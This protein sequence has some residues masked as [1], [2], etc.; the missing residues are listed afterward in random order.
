MTQT[1]EDRLLVRMETTL[2]RFEREMERGRTTAIKTAVDSERAWARAGNQIAA[3]SNRA[4]T[5]MA[6]LTQIS[7]SGRFVLQNTAA[8]LGD[9]AVQLESGTNPMRVMG[10]QFPQLL[11]GFGALGGSLGVVAPLLGVIAAIGFPVAGMLLQMGGNSEEASEKVKTFADRLAEVES[12]LGRAQSALQRAS[13]GGAEDLERIYGNVT[14]KVRD[15]SKALLDIE[16]RAAQVSVGVLLDDALNRDYRAEVE[17]MFG[18]VGAALVG[19]ASEEAK[20]QAEQIRGLISEIEAQI[21]TIT[22]TGQAEPLQL[23]A[24]IEELNKELAAVEG[25]FEDI[26]SLS[27]E[28]A[29]APD[30]LRTYQ[31]METRLAAA[32]EAGDFS[33]IAN[34]LSD[35]RSLLDTLGDTI[36]QEVRDK[37]TQAED[38]ARQFAKTLGEA[39]DVTND[40]LISAGGINFNRAIDGA[41]AL[42]NRLRISLGLARQIA[43]VAGTSAVGD[44]VFDERSPQFNPKAAAEARRQATLAEI[45]EENERINREAEKAARTGGSKRRGGSSGAGS[46][47]SLFEGAELQ[48]QSLERQIDMIGKTDREITRLTTRYRLLDEAKK[49]NV[50]LDQRHASTGRTVREEIDAQAEAVARLTD[51]LQRATETSEF[52][53][54]IQSDLKEGLLDGV[55]EANSFSDALDLVANRL[56]RAAAEALL[57][58][59]GPLSGGSGSGILGSIFGSIFGSRLAPTSSARPPIRR[60]ARGTVIDQPTFFHVGNTLNQMAEEGPEAVMPLTRLSNGKLGVQAAGGGGNVTF[61]PTINAPGAT[62]E[63]VQQIREAIYQMKAEFEPNVIGIVRKANK[64]N[65][66]L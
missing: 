31:E 50:N 58:N 17:D 60:H 44:E 37:L 49:R 51:Q 61:A 53:V 66:R 34:T 8:Q 26:G 1:V 35:M 59:E 33:E 7:G 20:E 36:S 45:R 6:R 21:N 48:I 28:L 63:T 62:A 2:R 22:S 5:G 4:A 9:V 43:A 12:A 41:E 32:R 47:S 14:A 42:A 19:S 56:K 18:A 65:V 3:N 23:R 54:D 13:H 29:V 64:R 15:L 39:D 40:I 25:R 52:Y 46:A 30:V 11:G 55:A 57:F 27:E 10:Q 16:I 24:E 38:Q